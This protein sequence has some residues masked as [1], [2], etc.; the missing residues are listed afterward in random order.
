M[1]PNIDTLPAEI[2]DAIVSRLDD[3]D[4]M[5]LSTTCRAL[6]ART[7]HQVFHTVRF[8]ND[9]R[10]ADAALVA[11]K[12]HGIHVKVLRFVGFAGEEDDN[13][14]V[15]PALKPANRD[16]LPPSALIL[17]EAN[18][19][20]LPSLEQFSISFDHDYD[21]VREFD[22]P[23]GPC[24]FEQP[25]SWDMVHAREA[26]LT[27]CRLWANT[28]KALAG[29]KTA[30]GLVIEN[31]S[32]RGVST[33]QTPEWRAYL[34]RLKTLDIRIT[35]ARQ[36][37]SFT[38]SMT[39]YVKDIAKMQGLFFEHLNT[40]Q[41]LK[42]S[43]RPEIPFGMHG[44]HH[45]PL[46]IKP[47]G[48][49]PA[50]QHLELSN[51][52]ISAD[53]AAFILSYKTQLRTVTLHNAQSAAAEYGECASQPL[54]WSAFFDALS[55]GLGEDESSFTLTQLTVT[56]PAPL[57]ET[58]AKSGRINYKTE[59]AAI[60]QVRAELRADSRRCL[61]GYGDLHG[62]H[63]YFAHDVKTNQQSAIEGVDQAAWDRL[64]AKLD[65]KR[66]Y[67]VASKAVVV[68]AGGEE[69]DTAWGGSDMPVS[70]LKTTTKKGRG[71]GSGKGSA[72]S[73][74]EGG[75]GDSA[76]ASKAG[77][78]EAGTTVDVPIRITRRRR[79]QADDA[80]RDQPRRSDRI[81]KM[82]GQDSV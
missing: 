57:S 43:I 50:L 74:V 8:S 35:A 49:M 67:V 33:F 42:I 46:P 32:P 21:Y 24:M 61:F 70:G 36:A 64:V 48:R 77:P 5:K 18:A 68:E 79:G 34:G 82:R 16:I 63:G 22:C 62:Y 53:L 76:E 15:E 47:T 38:N 30:T 52:F 29:N 39:G 14:D 80:Q 7:A 27:M 51:L 73:S 10:I 54:P 26:K 65:A 66:G 41:T 59:R 75:G 3:D 45:I 20:L 44:T 28:Y 56:S 60:K 78:A 37:W 6:R 9:P 71:A 55:L 81:A 40:V 1:T 72:A 13:P 25:E 17:F 2:I 58:E 12:N 31:W 23:H 11:V 19:A 69:N 4:V